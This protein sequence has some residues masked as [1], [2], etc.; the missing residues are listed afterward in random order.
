MSRKTCLA[1]M[2][3]RR[4]I[5]RSIVTHKKMEI[6]IEDPQIRLEALVDGERRVKPGALEVLRENPNSIA[7]LVPKREKISSNVLETV[8]TLVRGGV[9][10][11]EGLAGFDLETFKEKRVRGFR[12]K[13]GPKHKEIALV[14]QEIAK[15]RS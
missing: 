4:R 8:Y 12:P 9:V 7:N 2:G 1:L 15:G 3:W 13:F 14:L 10:T 6:P 5:K 11:I